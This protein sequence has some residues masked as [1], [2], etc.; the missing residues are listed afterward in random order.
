[1]RNMSAS[2]FDLNQVGTRQQQQIHQQ[3]QQQS[4]GWAPTA[5]PQVFINLT[6]SFEQIKLIFVY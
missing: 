4:A 6:Q 1:M 2:V 5:M 3:Q